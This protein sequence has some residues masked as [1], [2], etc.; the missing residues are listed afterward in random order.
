MKE[1]LRAVHATGQ[2]LG[3]YADVASRI[4]DSITSSNLFFTPIGCGR[5]ALGGHAELQPVIAYYASRADSS[6]RPA[7]A[8]PINSFTRVSACAMSGWSA[9]MVFTQPGACPDPGRTALACELIDARPAVALIMYGTNDLEHYRAETF[10]AA[11]D[12]IIETCAAAG[13]IPVLSTIPH[14][15]DS[16]SRAALVI[17]FNQIIIDVAGAHA[18]PVWNYWLAMEAPGMANGGIGAD[19]IHP[20]A[21]GGSD[22]ANF[23]LQGL[24]YGYNRRNFTALQVLDKV[25][26]VVILD[27][28]PDPPPP[29]AASLALA[30][31][32][33]SPATGAPFTLDV[34]VQP[35]NQVFD[36]WA[37]II[38]PGGAASSFDPSRPGSLVPGAHPLARGVQGL[39]SAIDVRLLTVASVPPGAA[40]TWRII[41][42]LVPPGRSP[43]DVWN[44]IPGCADD[45]MVT[46]SAP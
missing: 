37:V 12:S 15:Y 41:A 30:P 38:G 34:R 22:A 8:C 7:A 44:A 29:P 13:V 31:G 45:T 43:A 2:S 6:W 14:R 32:S 10:R 25:T 28:E 39:G 23:G 36:A 42:R 5:V 35:I 19:G 16:A 24:R 33:A 40:G 18:V 1:R 11:M 20:N 46:V 3:N 21:L 17:P 4:G 26:R 27:G 9:P